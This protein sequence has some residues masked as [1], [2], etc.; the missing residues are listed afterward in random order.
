MII[1]K[2]R[3]ILFISL[4]LSNYLSNTFFNLE[5]SLGKILCVHIFL[6][7]LSSFSIYLQKIIAKKENN[8]PSRF[9]TINFFRISACVLFLLPTII[10]YSNSD[11]SYIYNFFIIYFIYLLFEMKTLLKK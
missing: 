2:N 11:N 5:I 7:S 4:L 8:T 9:L 1:N 6:F 3:A 10:K